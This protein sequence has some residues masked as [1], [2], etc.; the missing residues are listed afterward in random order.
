MATRKTYTV[1]PR[2]RFL[3]VQCPE[4]NNDQIIFSH[5]S[6]EVK[7]TAC[8]FVLAK[9]SGGKAKIL[10]EISQVLE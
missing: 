4:C 6:R 2:S 7:C 3:V 1:E 10:G 5:A 9:P 8:S